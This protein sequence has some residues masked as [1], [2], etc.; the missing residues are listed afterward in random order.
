M[1]VLARCAI[2]LGLTL[3]CHAWAN[4]APFPALDGGGV[5]T[6]YLT[7]TNGSSYCFGFV[8]L[9]DST[10][11]NAIPTVAALADTTAN[12]TTFLSG[13]LNYAYNGTTWDRIPNGH[14]TAAKSLRVELPTDGTGVVGLNA[15]TNL[16]GKFGIDQTTPGTTNA[17]QVTGINA[18][19]NLIGK[20]GIDQTT[21]GTTNGV[22]PLPG[23]AGGWTPK[24]LNALSATVTT[25]KASA[26][27]LGTLQAANVNS[28]QQY[29]QVF[30]TSG[31]VT[32][33]TTTPVLSIPIPP[34]QS[35]NIDFGFGHNFANAIKVAATTTATGLTAPPTALDA[36]A[37][38]N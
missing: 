6:N 3:P 25:V 24:L 37:G 28:V 5:S 19:T 8:G 16:I 23:T 12:P 14:G 27:K 10:G 15:G 31:T 4:C 21:P 1:K 17:V 26:G 29:I 22:Q 34:G 30:D 32:L 18:G 35:I 38:Y 9:V 7:A 20:V 13:A 33:G 2:L 11:A 36:N